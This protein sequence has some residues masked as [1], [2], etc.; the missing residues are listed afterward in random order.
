MDE[1]VGVYIPLQTSIFK[2]A[3]DHL[4]KGNPLTKSQVWIY[5]NFLN[6]PFSVKA[7]FARSKENLPV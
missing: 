7:M 4:A 1:G 2:K 3:L 6:A 5:T